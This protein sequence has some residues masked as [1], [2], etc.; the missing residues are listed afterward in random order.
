MLKRFLA[1]WRLWEQ[2][3]EGMDDLHGDQLMNLEQRVVSLEKELA[4]LKE[5]RFPDSPIERLLSLDKLNPEG[6]RQYTR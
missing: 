3:L 6:G 4:L 5:R 2:A 1:K